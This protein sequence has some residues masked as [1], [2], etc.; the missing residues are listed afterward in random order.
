MVLSIAM[1]I[2]IIAL[3]SIPTKIDPIIY[4]QFQPI[5]YMVKLHIEL[6]LATLIT[7]IASNQYEHENDVWPIPL[8]ILQNYQVTGGVMMPLDIVESDAEKRLGKE[9]NPAIRPTMSTIVSDIASLHSIEE[10]SSRTG[11]REKGD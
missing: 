4:Q 7:K 8:V 10:V 2:L 11:L 5:T 1:D 3:E 9:S 6:S